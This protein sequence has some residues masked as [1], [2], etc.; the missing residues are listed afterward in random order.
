MY[1]FVF[2][3]ETRFYYVGQTTLDNV[4]KPSLYK[5]YKKLFTG[6]WC[7]LLAYH[8]LNLP[9]QPCEELFVFFVE[10]RFVHIIQGGLELLDSSDLP[11]LASQSARITGVSHCT[12]SYSFF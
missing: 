3:V 10:R 11:A 9:P 5:K 12:W 1:A 6:Q 2:L 8:S 7:N 4:D